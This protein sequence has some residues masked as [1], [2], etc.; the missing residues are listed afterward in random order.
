MIGTLSAKYSMLVSTSRSALKPSCAL[1]ICRS[2]QRVFDGLEL[3][4]LIFARVADVD[5]SVGPLCDGIAEFV[6]RH[7]GV[8]RGFA[9]LVDLL[10]GKRRIVFHCLDVGLCWS[11]AVRPFGP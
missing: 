8:N 9:N 5:G 11:R 2:L 10:V 6:E 7:F 3:T 1:A 4:V